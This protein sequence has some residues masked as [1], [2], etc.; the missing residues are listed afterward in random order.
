MVKESMR[1]GGE[2]SPLI[3]KTPSVVE[4]TDAAF[5]GI[6][7]PAQEGRKMNQETLS[8]RLFFSG[9]ELRGEREATGRNIGAK[10]EGKSAP[11]RALRYSSWGLAPII[12]AGQ[13][14]GG[15][16]YKHSSR[17]ELPYLVL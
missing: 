5:G 17:G 3:E 8:L 7:T 6:E 14:K 12:Y 2:K 15:L 13:A 4:K 10:R 16:K 1:I 9:R 11:A